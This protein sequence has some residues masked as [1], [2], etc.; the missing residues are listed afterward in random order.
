MLELALNTAKSKSAK[1]A[2]VRKL[3]GAPAEPATVGV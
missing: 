1:R 2:D 3:N